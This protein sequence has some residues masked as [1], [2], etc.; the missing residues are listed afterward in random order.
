MDD[1]VKDALDKVHE[2]INEIA[3]SNIERVRDGYTLP[4]F[5]QQ[6]TKTSINKAISAIDHLK[7]IIKNL[8]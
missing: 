2:A 3:W 1:K 5:A 7:S 6:G 8:S 4:H